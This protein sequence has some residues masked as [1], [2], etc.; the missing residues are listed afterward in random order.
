MNGG[1]LR[2]NSG[3]TDFSMFVSPIPMSKRRSLA[4]SRTA[5]NSYLAFGR[6]NPN[7]KDIRSAIAKIYSEILSKFI[8]ITTSRCT[9]AFLIMIS[10]ALFG[11]GRIGQV[12]AYNLKA[13]HKGCLKY[14][15]D[16]N[17][18][19]ATELAGSLGAKAV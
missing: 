13:S 17:G 11:A 3:R 8:R 5:E 1:R 2:S 16:V 4:L 9:A 10:F 6:W 18:P 19:A 12:H 15:I 14:V 7:P